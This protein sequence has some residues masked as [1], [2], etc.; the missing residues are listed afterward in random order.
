MNPLKFCLLLIPLT[1]C[2]FTGQESTL[3]DSNSLL[4]DGGEWEQMYTG[5][6]WLQSDGRRKGFLE[7]SADCEGRGAR[8]PTRQE[9][10]DAIYF[11]DGLR[12]KKE[13]LNLFDG[14][15]DFYWTTSSAPIFSGESGKWT[16]NPLHIQPR[17]RKARAE[18]ERFGIAIA[19]CVIK[20]PNH[21]D[22]VDTWTHP[23][24]G[25]VW[26]R[27]IPALETRADAELKCA[28]IGARLP[29]KKEFEQAYDARIWGRYRQL[30]LDTRSWYWAMEKDSREPNDYYR[31]SL[32]KG[33]CISSNSHYGWPAICVR[34]L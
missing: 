19:L 14:Y 23:E 27:K 1:A 5:L 22:T 9:L 18:S 30:G 12:W 20:D 31:C 4:Q 28:A 25:L 26:I 6:T 21:D 13:L 8:L 29:K 17:E 24:T 10:E 15:F 11:P 3:A 33:F 34:E 7:A 16:I 32:F 2:G